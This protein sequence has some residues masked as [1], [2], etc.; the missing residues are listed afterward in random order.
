MKEHAM[1]GSWRTTTVGILTA[2]AMIAI[3]ARNVLDADPS[4]VLSIEAIC[5]ALA[6]AGF[7]IFAR[8]NKVRSETVG[9][10]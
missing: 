5:A 9:A 3:Q 7:G 10:K 1:K 4:T 8:D 2:V 6:A